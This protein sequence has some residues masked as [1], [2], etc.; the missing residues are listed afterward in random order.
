MYSDW[1]ADYD[2]DK[3]CKVD[4]QCKNAEFPISFDTFKEAKWEEYQAYPKYLM[5]C[6]MKE[7]NII[8][9]FKQFIKMLQFKQNRVQKLIW[10]YWFTWVK[11]VNT[12]CF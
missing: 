10:S 12:D 3:H 1:T 2:K 9:S 11:E 7:K 8:N 5:F 6:G 4:Y